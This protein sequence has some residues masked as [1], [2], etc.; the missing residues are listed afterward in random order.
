[1]KFHTDENVSAA[2]A[3][4]LR[5][6]GF[7]VTTTQEAGLLRASDLDQ[8]AYGLREGRIVVSHDADMLRLAASNVAHA[9]IAYCHQGK[10]KAGPLLARLLM[11]A[12][13]VP[14]REMHNRIEFL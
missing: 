6:R 3:S 10:Y 9:G 14:E 1:M 12:G 7:D 2:V 8:L 4:G 13:R 5:R 11:L